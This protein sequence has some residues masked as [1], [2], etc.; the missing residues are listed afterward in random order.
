MAGLQVMKGHRA[1][2]GS[3]EMRKDK[4]RG[5]LCSCLC[6]GQSFIGH[7]V[8]HRFQNFSEKLDAALEL[9]ADLQ[10]AIA[11]QGL[12]YFPTLPEDANY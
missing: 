4:D 2:A 11:L 3:R 9:T 5:H 10:E 6:L 8:A 1:I 12:I 7:T